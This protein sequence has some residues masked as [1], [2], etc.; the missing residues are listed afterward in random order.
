MAGPQPGEL[1]DPD[2]AFHRPRA[3]EEAG[4]V[5]EQARGT[6]RI[7]HLRGEGLHAV[8]EYLEQVWGDAA[9][10]FRLMAENTPENTPE[11]TREHA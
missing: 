8:Q 6:S 3:A 9:Q 10:R 7:Y 5:A 11:N 1:A 4:L 2:T